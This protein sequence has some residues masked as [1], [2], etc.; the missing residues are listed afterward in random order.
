MDKLPIDLFIKIMTYLPFKDV[1]KICHINQKLKYLKYNNKWKNLID[2]TF[3]YI[4]NYQGNLMKI[5]NRLGLNE[6]KYNYRVY[7]QFIDLLDPITQL[8]IYNTQ[9]DMDSFNDTKF[10]DKQRFLALFI[11]EKNDKLMKYLPSDSYLPFI[12][13]LDG[14]QFPQKILNNM[15][16]K[17]T[18]SPLGVMMILKKG[19]D[20]H[21]EYD[22]ALRWDSRYGHTEIVRLL[23]KNGANV[24]TMIDY[25]LRFASRNGHTEVV[26]LLLENG[27]DIHGNN[28]QA[29][30]LASGNGHRETIRLL[31]E[32][33]A[34]IHTVD[35]FMETARQLLE[36]GASV[37]DYI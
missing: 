14:K 33:G 16:I 27:A 8:I 13:M 24:H 21:A 5:W 20:I 6:N 15:L 3:K 23:L 37:H 12:D 34:N 32:N 18:E 17:M 22:Y 26:K 7:T 29:L 36:I 10:N 25:P 19:A 35:D 11:L 30:I 2:D 1:V 9:N 4:Y 31:L 28:D